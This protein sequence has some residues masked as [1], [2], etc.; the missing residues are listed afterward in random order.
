M[1]LKTHLHLNT[2]HLN[3]SQSNQILY[4]F[5]RLL[6]A[7]ERSDRFRDIFTGETEFAYD[8]ITPK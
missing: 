1:D 7:I 4:N 6:T 5:V 3:N 8:S 2:P